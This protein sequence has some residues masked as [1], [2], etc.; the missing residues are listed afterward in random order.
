MNV[1]VLF[2]LVLHFEQV[3]ISSPSSTSSLMN[4]SKQLSNLHLLD[5]GNGTLFQLFVL[6]KN[7][8]LFVISMDNMMEN[9][10][11]IPKW[12]K[13]HARI[14][15]LCTFQRAFQLTNKQIFNHRIFH[16]G[17]PFPCQIGFLI[18]R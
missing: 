1:L 13:C 9:L 14:A 3:G 16:F 12:I 15:A 17:V 7:C 8:S 2:R 6:I 10:P 11:Q 18:I 5:D 4:K